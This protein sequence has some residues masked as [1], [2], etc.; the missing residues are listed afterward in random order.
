MVGALFFLL[1]VYYL[2]ERL[3]CLCLSVAREQLVAIQDKVAGLHGAN[4]ILA[5]QVM[6]AESYYDAAVEDSSAAVA[7][8]IQY[9]DL[10]AALLEASGGVLDVLSPVGVSVEECLGNVPGRFSEVIHH[11]VRRGAALAL[12]A[13]FLRS[14]EDLRDMASA[15]PPMEKPDDIGALAMEFRGAAGA[16]AEFESIEDIIRS[17]PRDM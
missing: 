11:A 10:H 5:K 12:A 4:A 8:A 1:E 16:I 6:E 14:S 7:R 3:L 2:D 15:C 13:A 17:T 9:R